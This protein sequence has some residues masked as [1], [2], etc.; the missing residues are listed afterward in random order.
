MRSQTNC[1]PF[2]FGGVFSACSGNQ[3]DS[4]GSCAHSSTPRMSRGE[5][6]SDIPT[7]P[8]SRTSQAATD[9]VAVQAQALAAKQRL[10][11]SQATWAQPPRTEPATRQPTSSPQAASQESPNS[12]RHFGTEVVEK[13]PVGSTVRRLLGREVQ[14]VLR[15][16][17]KS[18]AASSRWPRSRGGRTARGIVSALSESCVFARW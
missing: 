18:R 17:R 2:R 11:H 1:L 7:I 5:S 12:G 4:D 6:P 16:R 10:A 8:D 3:P 13:M 15:L 14:T 9:S